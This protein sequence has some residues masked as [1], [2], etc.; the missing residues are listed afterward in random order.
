MTT[1][2]ER[3]QAERTS[4]DVVEDL[5]RRNAAPRGDLA[6]SEQ[7]YQRFERELRKRLLLLMEK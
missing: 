6:V 2:V 7:D 3:Q 5:R 4:R 1:K